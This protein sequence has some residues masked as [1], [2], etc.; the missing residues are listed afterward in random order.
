MLFH[1]SCRHIYG[2]TLGAWRTADLLIG[3]AYLAR[4]EPPGGGTLGDVAA[5]GRPYGLGLDGDAKEAAQVN[6]HRRGQQSFCLVRQGRCCASSRTIQPCC[7]AI[8]A[9]CVLWSPA[10]RCRVGGEVLLLRATSGICIMQSELA[11]LRHCMTFGLAL[12]QH[13]PASQL[14]IFRSQARSIRNTSAAHGRCCCASSQLY[15]CQLQHHS[16]C[17]VAGQDSKHVTT[18]TICFRCCASGFCGGGFLGETAALG[19]AEAVLLPAARPRDTLH[20]LAHPRHPDHQGAQPAIKL[21]T[22]WHHLCCCHAEA[23]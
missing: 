2:E 13:R 6:S 19:P 7:S 5:A 16:C 20:R 15:V 9:I 8:C 11:T 18:M 22:C 21:V 1:S 10:G 23:P 12:R 4:R 14:A 17:T 3:L